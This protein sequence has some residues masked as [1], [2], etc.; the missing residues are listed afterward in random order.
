MGGLVTEFAHK[1][2]D[3]IAPGTTVIVTDAPMVRKPV[4]VRDPCVNPW[5]APLTIPSPAG[6]A[7]RFQLGRLDSCQAQHFLTGLTAH[8]RF[9]NNHGCETPDA[10]GG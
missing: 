10:A 4:D 6:S 3:E 9:P 5:S 7:H 8:G 1:V 2:A